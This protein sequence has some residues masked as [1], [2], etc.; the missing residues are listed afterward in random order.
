MRAPGS[1]VVAA[2][3]YTVTA[4]LAEAF[5][6][7]DYDPVD[8]MED[9]AGDIDQDYAGSQPK[10]VFEE[11]PDEVPLMVSWMMCTYRPRRRLMACH[12]PLPRPTPRCTWLP[13]EDL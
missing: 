5:D 4:R 10:A 9:D 8:H 12:A 3:K 13:Q 6:D 7:D 11:P 2:C 1:D